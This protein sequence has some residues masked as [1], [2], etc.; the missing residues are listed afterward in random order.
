MVEM[1]NRANG[2]LI[3]LG[4]QLYGQIIHDGQVFIIPLGEG[5]HHYQLDSIIVKWFLMTRLY[6]KILLI[7]LVFI[8]PLGEGGHHHQLGSILTHL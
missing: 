6:G 3:F 4:A 2:A 7:G 5:G 1:G 8:S